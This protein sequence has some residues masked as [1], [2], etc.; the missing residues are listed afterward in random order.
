MRVEVIDA[1]MGIRCASF[2][3]LTLGVKLSKMAQQRGAEAIPSLDTSYVLRR[4]MWQRH[5]LIRLT[6]R[7]WTRYCGKPQTMTSP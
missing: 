6:G 2:L 1:R 3:S 4:W 5:L 7:R